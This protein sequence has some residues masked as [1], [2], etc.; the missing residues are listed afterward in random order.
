MILNSIQTVGFANLAFTIIFYHFILIVL[1]Y[2]FRGA[3]MWAILHASLM[4]YC[5]IKKNS[6]RCDAKYFVEPHLTQFEV[7]WQAGVIH[8]KFMKTQSS[9]LR[10][11]PDLQTRTTQVFLERSRRRKCFIHQCVVMKNINEFCFSNL[12]GIPADSFDSCNGPR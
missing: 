1:L 12:P 2:V 5:L 3:L 10:N 8:W 6:Y 4:S 7:F 11:I 9:R